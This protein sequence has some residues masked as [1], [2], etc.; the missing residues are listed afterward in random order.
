MV[1]LPLAPYALGIGFAHPASAATTQWQYYHLGSRKTTHTLSP[2]SEA[3]NVR[4]SRGCIHHTDLYAAVDVCE[5]AYESL[6]TEALEFAVAEVRH[7]G[8]VGPQGAG[9]DELTELAD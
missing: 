9:G 2:F 6:E 4:S 7:S 3:K 5:K 8:L 1:I